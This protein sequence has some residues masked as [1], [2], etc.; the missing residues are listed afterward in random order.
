MYN[1]KNHM[2]SIATA[3][4]IEQA[5]DLNRIV[6]LCYQRKLGHIKNKYLIKLK[7]LFLS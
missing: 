7:T 4:K 5:V 3:S 2:A 1:V 6:R